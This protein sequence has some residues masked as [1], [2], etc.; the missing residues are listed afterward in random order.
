[1]KHRL[2]LNDLSVAER[3][4]LVLST[5]SVAGTTARYWSR[6]TG[7]AEDDLLS[8]AYEALCHASRVWQAS[9]DVSFK[10]YA[11]WWLRGYMQRAVKFYWHAG[12]VGLSNAPSK[13]KSQ[14]LGDADC[15]KLLAKCVAEHVPASEIAR[16]LSILSV[17]T[18]KM[19]RMRYLYGM[20][21]KEIGVAFKISTGRAR[22][23]ILNAESKLQ[24]QFA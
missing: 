16:M 24:E 10:S 15:R 5:V 17:R 19:V 3:Q 21:Y 2:Q 23:V 18:Q 4:A 1:M 20:T 6:N 11:T 13:L 12:F 8:A 9:K 22:Q 7:I 14:R